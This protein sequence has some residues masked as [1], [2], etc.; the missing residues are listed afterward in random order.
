MLLTHSHYRAILH[1]PVVYGTDVDRFRPERFL[2]S[3]GTLDSTVPYPDAAFGFGRRICPGK[4]LAQS[5]LWLTV[6]SLVACFN[7]AKVLD[8][9]GVEI[10]P[11]TDFIDGISS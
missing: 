11:S 5:A 7:F 2:K 1:N 3:N 4:A 10:E 9:D 8:K 6:A